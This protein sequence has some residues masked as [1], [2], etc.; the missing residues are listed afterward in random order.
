M[1]LSVKLKTVGTFHKV[2]YNMAMN[3][4]HRTILDRFKPIPSKEW[5]TF[6]PLAFHVLFTLSYKIIL[7][8]RIYAT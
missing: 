8:P 3:D 1:R 5:P 2:H 4:P 6:P 7:L